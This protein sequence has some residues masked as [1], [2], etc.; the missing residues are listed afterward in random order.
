LSQDTVF[1]NGCKSVVWSIP[2]IQGWNGNFTAFPTGTPSLAGGTIAEFGL[3]QLWSGFVP[4][5]RDTFDISTVPPG[6]GTL[7]NDGPHGFPPNTNNCVYFSQQSGFGTQQSYG[8]N[9]GIQIIP[10]STGSLVSQ[11]VACVGVLGNSTNSIGFPNDT[12][13]PKQQTIECLSAPAG[14]YVVNFLDP[15]VSLQ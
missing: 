5:L 8:Y 7:C 15:V 4:A 11:P 1:D 14:N 6:I 12:A 9:I 10:P 3:N 2:V 13:Y